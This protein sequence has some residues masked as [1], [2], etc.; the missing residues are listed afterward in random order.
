MT[1]P[2]VAAV[3]AVS[4]QVAPGFERVRQAFADNFSQRDELGAA[5][6]MFYQDRKV[7]DLWGGI[8]EASSSAP[9]HEDTLVLA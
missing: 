5:T 2:N 1:Q 8:A 3:G 7:V 6:T 4:G 9:W